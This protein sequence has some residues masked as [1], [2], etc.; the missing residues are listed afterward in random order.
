MRKG[1]E[2]RDGEEGRDG[3]KEGR[4]EGRGGREGKNKKREEITVMCFM[5]NWHYWPSPC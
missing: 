2:K 4:P 5:F 1:E 3:E